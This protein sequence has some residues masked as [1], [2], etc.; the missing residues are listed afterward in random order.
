MINTQDLFICTTHRVAMSK[1]PPNSRPNA[2]VP[3]Q[4]IGSP[5]PRSYFIK[6]STGHIR[7]NHVQMQLAPPLNNL[8]PLPETI[9]TPIFLTNWDHTPYTLLHHSLHLPL[10][11]RHP[12]MSVHYLLYLQLQQ[13]HW[14]MSVHLFCHQQFPAELH[15]HCPNQPL[16]P[17]Y[18]PVFTALK[19]QILLLSHPAPHI[20]TRSGRVVRKPARYWL[21][22]D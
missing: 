15:G 16:T 18:H 17:Q 7:R 14:I 2:W 21:I 20:V 10:P 12:M 4:I 3:G 1:P 11:Q 9:Q 6:T 8:N 19:F 5:G 22:I 13:Q